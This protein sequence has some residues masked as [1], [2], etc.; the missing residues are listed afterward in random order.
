[1]S[2]HVV[3]IG[4]G[5][6]GLYAARSLGKAGVK[7]TLVDRRNF[8]LFQPLLYQVA[9]GGLSPGDIASPL[10][11]VLNR[12]KNVEVLIGDMKGLD[13]KTRTVILENGFISYDTLIL[14]T[15]VKH[16]YF[17][18]DDW[19]ETAPGLKTVE[20]AIDIRHRVMF[21]FEAAELET[22]PVARKQWLTFVIVGGGPTGVELAGSLGELA[23]FTLKND[24]RRINPEEAKIVLLEG[25]DRLLP[26]FPEQLSAT[27][28]RA[29]TKLGV[30]VQTRT[31]LTELNGTQLSLKSENGDEKIDAKTVLWAAGVK[32]SSIGQIVSDSTGVALDKAGRV[33]VEPDLTVPNHPEILI[34]GDLANLDDGKGKS[35]PGVAPV[36]IQQGRYVADIIKN[37]LKGIESKPFRY[38]DKGS[39]AVIGRN[40]AVA[41]FGRFKFSGFSAWILWVFV[42]IGY[43]IEFDNKIIVMFEWAWNYLTRNRGARLITGA[44]VQDQNIKKEKEKELIA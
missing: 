11:G 41:Y 43:L 38:R 2:H 26:T 1:M 9:T 42:H 8:H 31:L 18:R 37:R 7:V 34:A 29:L 20:D 14:A 10:R 27:A 40:C 19:A 24:F 17:G 16:H 44:E 30:T 39:L 28:E 25:T 15:G 36:A 35:L 13:A 12:H 3:I 33:N 4:G 5:F 32:A 6:A 22:N 23:H 21:A